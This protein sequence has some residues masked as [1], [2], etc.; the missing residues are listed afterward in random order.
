[1]HKLL[2]P[3]LVAGLAFGCSGDAPT[4]VEDG[5]LQP[6]FATQPAGPFTI[7]TAIDFSSFPFSGTFLVDPGSGL[8]GCNGGTFVD[9]PPA[10]S[11]GR[12]MIA[13]EFTCDDGP[14]VG[15]FTANFKATAKPGPGDRNGHWTVVE[16]TGDFANLRGEGDFSVVVDFLTLTGVETLTGKIHFDP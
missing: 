10:Q 9:T 4:G 11:G 2:I 5:S 7:T 14:G 1:M 12:G 15:T 13:K 6:L 16:G 3:L 8:L